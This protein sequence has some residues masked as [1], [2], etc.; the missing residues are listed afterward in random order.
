MA[1]YY[2]T[3][4]C[5]HTGVVKIIGPVQDRERKRKYYFSKM[6]PDCH[7]AKQYEKRME[8]IEEAIK[9]AEEWELPHLNG[10]SNQ[11]AWANRIRIQ[12]LKDF[13]AKCNECTPEQAIES[14][15]KMTTPDLWTNKTMELVFKTSAEELLRTMEEYLMGQKDSV[16]WIDHHKNNIFS[17]VFPY[18]L[19]ASLKQE[20]LLIET[21][22]LEDAI[23]S[24][25]EVLH[26]GIVYIMQQKNI[27]T[28]VYP[29][30][31]SFA[32]IVQSCMMRWNR[33]WERELTEQTGSYQDRAGELGNILL[34]NGFR[35][36]IQDEEARKKAIDGTY[37]LECRRWIKKLKG[38]DAFLI[39]FPYDPDLVK[40]AMT[41]SH[42][43][44]M[45]RGVVVD[46]AY[47]MEV[48]DFAE[49]F[50]FRFTK[51]CQ[52]MITRYSERLSKATYILP[53]KRMDK[54]QVDKLGLILNDTGS[55]ISDLQDD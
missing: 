48:A 39:V 13:Y 22:Y 20:E 42:A 26:D 51:K 7:E 45:N 21:D 2:G 18:S 34:N 15:Y 37:E 8:E 35:I 11:T 44:W 49:I 43:R 38:Q 1:N 36:S 29:K 17:F 27:L 16:W 55:I 53:T 40:M 10:T 6:C 5:G 3:Y 9:L 30:D 52:D 32:S 25:K 54:E 24:P 46:L 4:I 33:R 12:T 23:I 41:I 19:E 28:A 14:F 47:Y 31:T 50:D